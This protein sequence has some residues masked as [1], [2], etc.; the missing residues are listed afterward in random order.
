MKTNKMY[1]YRR[2]NC[3]RTQNHISKSNCFNISYVGKQIQSNNF[4]FIWR[5]QLKRCINYIMTCWRTELLNLNTPQPW[6]ST[7]RIHCCMP[8]IKP[9]APSH[10]QF[11]LI[12]LVVSSTWVSEWV[13]EWV[14][15]VKYLGVCD[16]RWGMDWWIG[17]IAHLYTLLGS[18]HNYRTITDLQHLQFTTAPTEP[19]SSLLCLNQLFP[20]NGF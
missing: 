4:V 6:V 10:R 12:V 3:L 13:S 19:F 8:Q 18:T 5:Q 20:G 11:K 15:S 9:Q 7:S 14:S 17:S 1:E 16:Y 2:S